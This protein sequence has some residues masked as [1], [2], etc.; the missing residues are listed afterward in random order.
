MIIKQLEVPKNL[1]DIDES[2]SS[3]RSDPDKSEE[4]E[5][6]NPRKTSIPRFEDLYMDAKKRQFRR[7]FI[8]DNCQHKE[9]TFQP[10]VNPRSVQPANGR[11]FMRRLASQQR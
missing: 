7:K 10:A 5:E 11:S 9:C 8:Y 2:E 6:D 1:A 3:F 4:T